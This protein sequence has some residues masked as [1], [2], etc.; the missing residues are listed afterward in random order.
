CPVG[1]YCPT[2]SPEPIPCPPGKYQDQAGKSQCETCP[3][4]M[5]CKPCPGG[6]FCASA[7]LSSPSGPCLPGYYCTSEAR[8][9]NPVQDEAGSFCPAG[10]YCPPGSSKPEPCPAGT[11]LPQAG[12]VYGNACVPCP[13]GRFC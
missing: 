4:G 12:M 9:P 1:H 13:A 3:A 2:G 6:M 11:F 7:G 5:E 10:H 8:V